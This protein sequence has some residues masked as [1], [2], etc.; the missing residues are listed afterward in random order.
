MHVSHLLSNATIDPS[1]AQWL[2]STVLGTSR[3]WLL[4]HSEHEVADELTGI[5][6]SLV[7]RRTQGEPLAY[8]LGSQ[9]FFGRS[10][11][12]NPSVLIPRPA[13]EQLLELALRALHGK[14]ISTYSDI[15]TDIIAWHQSKV[16]N[17]ST[18]KLVA[19]IGTGSGCIAVTLACKRPDL[20]IIATDI[21][22]A[23]IQVARVNARIHGVADRIDFRI[24]PG[25]LPLININEPFVII[26]N[27]PYIPDHTILEK[28]VHD[29]EPHLALFAGPE[30]TDVLQ[31]IINQANSHTQCKGW[32]IE[33]KSNQAHR[34]LPRYE[35]ISDKNE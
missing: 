32:I 26:S 23:A 18:V 28:D 12:V 9:Q 10:F 31:M 29:F 27:P 11:L 22:E 7:L 34:A 1:D 21:S 33:C 5:F 30:G 20:R 2:L 6:Q 25:N 17:W 15:D 4:A 24:G 19:D 8:L 35:N 3:T 14:E 13:T 16:Q